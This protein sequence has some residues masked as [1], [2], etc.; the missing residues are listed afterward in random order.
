[1]TLEFGEK[2]GEAGHE[3]FVTE[4]HPP[5]GDL[6]SLKVEMDPPPRKATHQYYP[7]TATFHRPFVRHIFLYEGGEAERVGGYEVLVTPRAKL[8]DPA[9]AVSLK[10]P[11]QVDIPTV[12]TPAKD[13]QE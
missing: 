6:F 12:E 13:W 5:K 9:Q 3:V 1:V 4:R 7:E 2:R 10:E 11:F 8:T